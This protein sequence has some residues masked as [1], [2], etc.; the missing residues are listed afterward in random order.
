MSEAHYGIID[1][2]YARVFTLCRKIAYDE[3]YA[4]MMHG[5]FTRDLDL[6]AVPWRERVAEPQHLVNRILGCELAGLVCSDDY[7]T[8]KPHGRLAWVF[9]FKNFDDP[10]YIDFSVFPCPTSSNASAAT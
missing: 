2:D 5:S 10:R 1:P 9:L 3:G 6:I 7:P 4:L 8:K